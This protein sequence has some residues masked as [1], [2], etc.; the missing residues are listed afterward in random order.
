MTSTSLT[1]SALPYSDWSESVTLMRSDLESSPCDFPA[2][3]CAAEEGINVLGIL[4]S[5]ILKQ[6]D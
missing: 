2:G 1:D 5:F 3:R 6:G 4:K